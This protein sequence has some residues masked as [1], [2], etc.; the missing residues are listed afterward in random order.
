[1]T[2]W[3]VPGTL[4]WV[5]M[6]KCCALSVFQATSRIISRSYIDFFNSLYNDCFYDINTL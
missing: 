1:M 4:A 2:D 5:T 6:R 3:A